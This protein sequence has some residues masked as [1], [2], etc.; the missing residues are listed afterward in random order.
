MVGCGKVN[1]WWWVMRV[2]KDRDRERKC[3]LE[4]E[5]KKNKDVAKSVM[6]MLYI[7]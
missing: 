4:K 2:E 3:G 6:K 1:Q 5:E 7:K